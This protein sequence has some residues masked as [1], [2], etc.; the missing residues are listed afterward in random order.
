MRT[1]KTGRVSPLEQFHLCELL[2]D[3]APRLLSAALCTV[4]TRGTGR[5]FHSHPKAKHVA[6]QSHCWLKRRLQKVA[7]R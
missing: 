6:K 5:G 1:P 3:S 4:E 2:T 7:G